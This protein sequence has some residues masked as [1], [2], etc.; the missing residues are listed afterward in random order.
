L[1]SDF[2]RSGSLTN[3]VTAFILKTIEA[4]CASLL[5]LGVPPVARHHTCGAV[6][7]TADLQEYESSTEL[8]EMSMMTVRLLHGCY[9]WFD[10]IQIRTNG[11]IEIIIS[12]GLFWN[13]GKGNRIRFF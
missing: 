4:T 7:V 10:R 11:E 2:F 6:C 5:C 3:S 12:H 9:K 13:A 1:V 8:L